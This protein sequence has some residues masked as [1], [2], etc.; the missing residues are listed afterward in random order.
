MRGTR[1]LTGLKYS[2]L[3]NKIIRQIRERI[4]AFEPEK[5]YL[6]GSYARGEADDI[7]DIDLVVIKN[8]TESFFDRIRHVLRILNI[9]RAIDVFVYTPDEFRAMFDRGNAFVEMVVEDGVVIYG[10]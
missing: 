6:I 5:V 2:P 1:D 3:R 8:S 9:N 10:E 7:S 4:A